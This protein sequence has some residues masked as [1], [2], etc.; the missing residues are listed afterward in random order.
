MRILQD[1]VGRMCQGLL[2][3][4]AR[5][6]EKTKQTVIRFASAF[7]V[8]IALENKGVLLVII[9]LWFLQLGAK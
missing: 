6:N 3:Y 4:D 5:T 1:L 8:E 2:G 7:L 9:G